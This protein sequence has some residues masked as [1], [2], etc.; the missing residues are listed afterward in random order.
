MGIING[1]VFYLLQKGIDFIGRDALLRQKTEGIKKKFVM[2]TLT[3]HDEMCDNYPWRGEPI[4][5]NGQYIG[6]VTS[7]AYGYTLGHMV[8]LGFIN[9]PNGLVNLS[10]ITAKNAQYEI[11]IGKKRFTAKA[12]AYPPKIEA[13]N[14]GFYLP[15]QK[16]DKI[17]T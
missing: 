16:M 10:Y 5:R 9:N 8:C 12:H 3:D 14:L 13:A 4:Y 7:S 11:A 17:S 15:A 6:N 2:F 1:L